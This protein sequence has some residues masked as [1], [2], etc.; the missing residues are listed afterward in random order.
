M[1]ALL[2]LI[3]SISLYGVSIDKVIDT[4]YKNN[5]T[6]KKLQE[7]ILS[8]DYDILNSDLYKNPVITIGVNDI[9]LDEPKKRDLE[10][11][12]TNFISFSQ[13]IT[14]SDKLKLKTKIEH[15]N[16]DIIKLLLKEEK[17]KI[18]KDIY[19]LYFIIEELN[20]KIQLNNK[21]L[22]NTQKIKNYNNN[23]IQ[24][25]KAFQSSIQN[26]IIIDKTKLKIESY[27]ELISQKYAQL[28]EITNK[29]I[30]NISI[31]KHP[32]YKDQ[33]SIK[34][35]LIL[36]IQNTQID[37]ALNKKDLAIK[38]KTPNYTISGGYY[39]RDSFDDYINIALKFPINIYSKEKN[40]VSKSKKLINIEK[41]RYNELKNK[42]I[43][44]YK[45]S[46][47]QYNLASKSIEFTKK[48]IKHLKKEKE[49]I[50]KQNYNT[51]ILQIL[52]LDNKILKNSIDLEKYKKNLFIAQTNLSYLTS[53]LTKD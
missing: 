28:L 23:Q 35:H 39:N 42:L 18:A 48:I 12:Q 51:S 33:N 36:Q 26:D 4:A 52:N 16:K 3:I 30:S 43:K 34:K 31:K 8:K 25:T 44:N 19:N 24:N 2:L 27:K 29:D 49:L 17:N 40:Q 32:K 50:S 14:W 46:L 38:N 10:A 45:I 41:N 5:P 11:M 20:K 21:I 37:K 22:Q 47:S 1:K 53:N 13:E 7:Q 15:I 6:I 9:N